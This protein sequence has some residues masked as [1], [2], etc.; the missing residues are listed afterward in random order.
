LINK[1]SV[2]LYRLA[3][4]FLF[5]LP[6]ELSH[7]LT[8]W[9]LDRLPKKLFGAPP[10]G[11]AKQVMGL[12]FPNAVGL[13][14]G[15]DKNADHLNGLAKLGF[16]FIEVGT[17]TPKPQPG[18]AKPRLFR[19]K[20]QRAIIN[21]FGFNS[22][23]VAHMVEQLKQ[24]RFDGVLGVNIGKNATTPNDRAVDDYL[25]C[26]ERVYPYAD[27]IMVNISSPNTKDLRQLQSHQALYQL[28]QALKSA[29]L[30][31]AAESDRYVPLCVKIAPDLDE[32]QVRGIAEVLLVCQIDAVCATNTTITRP[33]E[34]EPLFLQ[35]GGLSGAP[36]TEQANKVLVQLR[37]ALAGRMPIIGVGGIM[38]AMD[39]VD[40]AQSG[41]D[42]VQVYSGL[43]YQG[44]KLV[45][46]AI[47]ALA[48][49]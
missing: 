14:A 7:N 37:D 47:K 18:N 11:K 3:R 17:V 1:E 40:K 42:L 4:G 27:Y 2:V 6:A 23:G 34:Q 25:Y 10:K 46:D 35:T 26:L 43:I 13:A 12:T 31:L 22:K 33:D 15:L 32:E 38:N 36:L 8:L 19:L 5:C 44:P 30:R 16:G 9:L 49:R 39:A 21:R 24:R 20:K 28:L 29:Q 41:A 48:N 45:H